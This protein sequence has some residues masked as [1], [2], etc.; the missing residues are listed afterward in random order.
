MTSYELYDN[1]GKTFDRYTLIVN[2]AVIVLSVN[3]TSSQ[4]INMYCCQESE[5]DK[6]KLGDRIE[7]EDLPLETYVAVAYRT[8]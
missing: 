1:Y 5:I 2:G 4:G 6:T 8:Y 3:A 7:L